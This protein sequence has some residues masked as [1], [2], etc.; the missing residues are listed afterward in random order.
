[1]HRQLLCGIE[2]L[3]YCSFLVTASELF[4][5]FILLQMSRLWKHPRRD[6]QLASHG[7]GQNDV[8]Q[9]YARDRNTLFQ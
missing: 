8:P 6:G 5:F 1:M 2:F 7:R 4:D 9:A 3:D